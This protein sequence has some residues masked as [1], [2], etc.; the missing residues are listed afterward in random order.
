[1][2]IIPM[3]FGNIIN[4]LLNLIWNTYYTKKLINYGF[5]E[6]MKD[7]LPILIHSL[8]MGGIV[9]LIVNYMM[10]IWLKLIVGVL[11]GMIY[12]IL[13]AYIMKFPEMNEL[14]SILKLKRK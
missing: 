11:C 9:V 3:C 13:V 1:M 12:Y 5:F 4:T 10:T 2:G 6:Q 14:L 8:V 7:L